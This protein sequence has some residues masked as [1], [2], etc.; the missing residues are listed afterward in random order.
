MFKKDPIFWW[1][2]GIFIMALLLAAITQNQLW[3]TL[4]IGSY[5]LRPTLASLGVA[6][7]YVDER[8]LSI[9]YRSSNIAFV[10]MIIVSIIF[11]AKLNAEGNDAWEIFN[12]IIVAGLAVKALFNVILAKNLREGA[13]KII[14]SAGLLITLFV[15]MG[16]VEEGVTLRSLQRL[17]PPLTIVGLGILSKHYPRLV[18]VVVFIATAALEFVILRKGFT[19]AQIGTA[20]IIGIPLITA[21]VCLYLPAKSDITIEPVK[22]L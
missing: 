22:S 12:L 3:L 19:W 11:A 2:S 8:Q 16:S 18:G 7:R 4:L 17:L 14:I 21:G 10:V 6:H 20:F 1:A 9:H 5:L 13:T 15:A